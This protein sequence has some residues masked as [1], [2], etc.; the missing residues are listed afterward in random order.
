M[1]FLLN[2]LRIARDLMF[3][4]VTLVSWKNKNISVTFHQQ[5]D[6]D[7]SGMV[8]RWGLAALCTFLSRW[9]S[10]KCCP[11]TRETCPCRSKRVPVP[12]GLWCPRRRCSQRRW[13]SGA[14]D[15]LRPRTGMTRTCLRGVWRERPPHP[16]SPE[17][18]VMTHSLPHPPV[19]GLGP[20]GSSLAMLPTYVT[21]HRSF[22]RTG[23]FL[24]LDLGATNFHSDPRF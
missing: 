24:G 12:G 22:P 1:N 4:A 20:S 7:A 23:R 18:V 16:L 11:G 10:A 17:G 13:F 21:P 8:R 6:L 19:P 2:G 3:F 5:E 14:R 15:V 9:P